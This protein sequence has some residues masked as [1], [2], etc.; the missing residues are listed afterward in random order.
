MSYMIDF[1]RVYQKVTLMP[2][3]SKEKNHGPK[4]GHKKFVK[5]ACALEKYENKLYL[6]VIHG[7]LKWKLNRPRHETLPK[8]QSGQQKPLC[9]A[10][11]TK[12][13]A[14]IKE[15]IGGEEIGL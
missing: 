14:T 12:S 5:T 1:F 2:R 8:P 4:T 6:T 10:T 3:N 13:G 15:T 11:K 9:P 7:K